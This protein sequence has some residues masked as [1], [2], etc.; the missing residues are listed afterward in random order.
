MNGELKPVVE[1]RVLFNPNTGEFSITGPVQDRLMM[2]GLLGMIQE[3]VAATGRTQP[4]V[5]PIRRFPPLLP[6]GAPV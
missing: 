2:Y 6:P 3:A 1:L 4:M 5:Q